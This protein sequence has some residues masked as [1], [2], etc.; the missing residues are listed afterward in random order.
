MAKG[1]LN[2]QVVVEHGGASDGSYEAGTVASVE[3]KVDG[4][5]LEEPQEAAKKKKKKNKSKKKKEVPEQ[6]D[7]PTIPVT[8][9]FPSGEFPEGEIQQYKDEGCGV[10]ITLC[11]VAEIS[12]LEWGSERKQASLSLCLKRTI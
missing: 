5:L 11:L 9:L 8:E 3:E 1:E 7:P 6:T 4:L 12:R 10:H 2:G